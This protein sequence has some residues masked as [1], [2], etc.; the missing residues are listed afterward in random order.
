M[1]EVIPF[2]RAEHLRERAEYKASWDRYFARSRLSGFY[3][4]ELFAMG[5][6]RAEIVRY[7]R[8]MAHGVERRF[9][10][11]DVDGGSCCD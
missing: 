6:S 3:L 10:M 5:N 1:A 9:L 4:R 2:V 7:L 11:E 8:E